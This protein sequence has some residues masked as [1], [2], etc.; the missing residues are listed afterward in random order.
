MLDPPLR[1]ALY[2]NSKSAMNRDPFSPSAG[3]QL[4]SPGYFTKNLKKLKLLQLQNNQT[5]GKLLPKSW[6][7]GKLQEEQT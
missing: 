6:Q 3:L 4:N 5:T 1:S 2:W 7:T